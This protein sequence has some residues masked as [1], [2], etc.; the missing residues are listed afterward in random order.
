MTSDRSQSSSLWRNLRILVLLLILLFV[1]LNTYFDRMYSTDWD[2]PLRV[3]I[4]PINGDGSEVSER[5]IGGL[6]SDHFI[7]I[8]AFFESEAREYGLDMERPIRILLTKQLREMPPSIAPSANVLSVI[9]WSLRTRY[10][11]WK[12]AEDPNGIPPDI[13]LFVLYHDPQRSAQLPHSIGL[14]KGLFGIVNVFAAR[15]MLGAN[16]TVIAHELLHTLGASDKYDPG[17][18]LPIYP[19][20]YAEPDRKPLHPQSYAELMAGR[21]PITRERAEIPESLHEVLVGAITAAEI[22]WTE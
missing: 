22:G 20:G 12:V 4:Y 16:D 9:W 10:W 6:A 3:A 11:A 2:I 13:K 7:S 15:D 5:F 1:A 14:Q 8:E 18:T 21:I 17:T 19:I